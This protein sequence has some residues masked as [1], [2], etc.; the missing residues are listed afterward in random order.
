MPHEFFPHTGDIG[1]RVWGSSREA[2]FASAARAFVEVLV[3]PSTIRVS[4]A[5]VVTC[6]APDLDLLLHGFLCELLFQFDAR[7]RLV[8]DAEVVLARDGSQW[9]LE[10]TTRGEPFDP[11]RHHLK[12]LVKGVTY[13]QLSVVETADAWTG[14]VVFDI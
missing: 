12:V 11:A 3:D 6:R 9:V 8:S 7:G 2:L 13:H 10:A 5:I 1:V 14:T 4:D